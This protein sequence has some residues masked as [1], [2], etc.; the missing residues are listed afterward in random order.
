[1]P[2]FF[3]P[4]PGDLTAQESPPPWNLPSKAK[5]NANGRWSARGGGGGGGWGWAKL[6]LADALSDALTICD[7]FNTIILD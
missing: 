4:T 6:E 2:S 5:K 3:I 1:M 7:R